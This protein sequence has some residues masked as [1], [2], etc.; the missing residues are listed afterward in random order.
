MEKNWGMGG[1]QRLE[2]KKVFFFSGGNFWRERKLKVEKEVEKEKNATR[3]KTMGVH[4]LGGK[5]FLE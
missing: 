2:G 3:R 5:I 1:V 4:F